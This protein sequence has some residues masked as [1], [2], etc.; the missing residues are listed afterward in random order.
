MTAPLNSLSNH[1]PHLQLIFRFINPEF[2]VPLRRLDWTSV[3]SLKPLGWVGLRWCRYGVIKVW[4]NHFLRLLRRVILKGFKSRGSRPVRYGT[5]ETT[6]EWLS[7]IG[8]PLLDRPSQTDAVYYVG[9]DL[10][11]LGWLLPAES[12]EVYFGT[13]LLVTHLA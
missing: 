12:I 9:V 13:V 11:D 3:K 6:A 8:A 4:L 10:A 2:C 7:N 5:I 1:L